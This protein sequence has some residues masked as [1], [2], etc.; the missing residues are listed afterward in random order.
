[1]GFQ[2]RERPGMGPGAKAPHPWHLARLALGDHRV[3]ARVAL[4]QRCWGGGGGPSLGVF[5]LPVGPP[6]SARV[7]RDARV[8]ASDP[9]VGW[10]PWARGSLGAPVSVC[11]QP[12]DAY[13]A[14]QPPAFESLASDHG[15]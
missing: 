11:G 13:G 1:M 8:G 12:F 9:P 10:G 7:Q 14:P 15:R 6:V 3:S 2:V 4:A 5:G